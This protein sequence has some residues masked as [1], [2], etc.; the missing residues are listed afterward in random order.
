MNLANINGKARLL[1]VS[2]ALHCHHA[3]IMTSKRWAA[4]KQH[5]A[6]HPSA[7]PNTQGFLYVS[8]RMLLNKL[9][10]ETLSVKEM[11]LIVTII[12]RRINS[13]LI[14]NKQGRRK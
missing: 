3:R 10:K 12:G 2:N 4:E 8:G 6:L 5:T 1:P 9:V 7:V 13:M 14:R 11:E